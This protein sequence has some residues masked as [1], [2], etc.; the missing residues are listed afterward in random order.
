MVSVLWRAIA[1]VNRSVIGWMTKNLLSRVSPYFGRHVKPLV[2]AAIAVLSTD[3]SA[4]GP[5]GGLWLMAR[6]PYV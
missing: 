2:P 4:L 5:R 3:L 1:E 6:S